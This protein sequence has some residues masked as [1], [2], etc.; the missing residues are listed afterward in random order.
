MLDPNFTAPPNGFQLKAGN[1]AV[2][3][4]SAV[5]QPSDSHNSSV[6]G[7]IIEYRADDANIKK[8]LG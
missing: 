2:D 5:L 6:E 1:R 3:Q 4:Q 8:L 7:I